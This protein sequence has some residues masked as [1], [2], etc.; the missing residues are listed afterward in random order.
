MDRLADP[1]LS[2]DE[3]VK[4]LEEPIHVM[5]HS[6]NPEER[7][8]AQALLTNIQDLP[9]AWMRV[10]KVL[11]FPPS[12]INAKFFALQI[13]EKLIKYRWKT[14]P[15]QTCESIRNYV[16][17][18]LIKLSETDDSL[19]RERVFVSKLN[20]I[21]V[22]IVKQE[23]PANWPSF[24]TEIVGASRSSVSLCEN[25]MKILRLLSEEVFEFST[26]EMTQDKIN[27][28]KNQ[29]NDDFSRVFQ[30]CQNV[31]ESSNDLQ[32]T[33][34]TLLVATLRTLEKFLSWIPLGYILETQLIEKLVSFIPSPALRNATLPC[35][36]EISSLQA[37]QRYSARFLSLYVSFAKQ[38][39]NVLPPDIDIATA[40]DNADDDTQRFVMDLALFFTGFFRTHGSL[41]DVEGP[42]Q[43]QEAL[44]IGHEYLVRISKVS[45]IEVF[46]T[47]VEWWFRLATELYDSVCLVPPV[48]SDRQDLIVL[49]G[50]NRETPTPAN[51]GLVL[52]SPDVPLPSV[53][54]PKRAFYAHILADVRHVMISRMAKPEEVLI[55]EDENGEI[56]RETTKDTDAIALYKT[57]KET[58]VGLTHLDTANTEN[59]MLTK[60][61]M[62][63]DNSEWSWNNLNTLCWAIGS[64]SGAMGEEEERKFLVTVIK[65]LLQLVEMK[66]GKDNKAV[67]ASNI[68]YVVGQ[69]PRFLRA[70]WKFLKTV[71]NKLFEFM[72]E[73]HPGVQDMACD[74]FLKIS[75]KCRR[76][77]VTVQNGESRAFIVE[78]LESVPDIILK[79]EAH[80]IHSFYEACGC[81]IASEN[82]SNSRQLI[83]KL[84]ELPN[85]SWQQLLYS[86]SFSEDVLRQREKMKS[87]TSILKTNS[88][89]A[90]PL[91]PA[92]F[93][94]LE[95]IFADMLKVYK[96]Y[97][98]L[99]QG[100]V[101]NGG[102]YATK[103]ADV[104]N[105]RAVKREVLQVI[106]T[107]ISTADEKIREHIESG[108]VEPL[109]D[110]VLADYYNSVPDAREPAVLSLYSTIV[111]YMRS[112]LPT[113]AIRVIFKSLVGCTLDMIKNNFQDFPDARINFFLLLRAINS[114]NFASLFAL[115]E[116]PGKAE[117]EFRIIINAIVW[118]F[119]HTERNVAETGLQTLLEMLRSVDF[120]PFVNYFYKI[121][122][123]SILNDIL[124]VLTDTF[125][126]PG[127]KLHAQI[128]KHL[129]TS[130]SSG[131]ITEPI[132][133][134]A[135]AEEMVLAT[136]N[137]N[138]QASNWTYLRNHLLKILKEAFPNLTDV[139]VTD[140]VTKLLSGCDEKTFKGHL[141]DFL[142]QTKEFSGGDNT[143]LFEGEKQMQMLEK[144][145][146]EKERLERTPGLVAPSN[147]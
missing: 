34:P 60:L 49:P 17:N 84:F 54:T 105:M 10:D 52:R 75:Q 116:N 147:F 20:L 51:S 31:F 67:V 130:V 106:E 89:V 14:L 92:Y 68:M 94:Q 58:L 129:I 4:L 23:W 16:V 36:V 70:H 98:G 132:W 122:F 128:L 113:P 62:Q 110:A 18:K 115:D 55:V 121:Y 48:S 123:K 104:R 45:D 137:G 69:Y 1:S 35:L 126:R 76:Q 118:A 9:N 131:R 135:T 114:H 66:R 91:G 142:V 73:T 6:Q 90:A 38:L 26:G 95:W 59:I 97:S 2:D 124:S 21:L 5:Y 127:F 99:I 82:D 120:S 41:L 136:T 111:T 78:M 3:Y 53:M 109:T 74:T 81:I 107:A 133:D 71:V 88:R 79:L 56:V 72:H 93:V 141:R 63:I 28:L 15:R 86:A 103:S 46:K 77:F 101:A 102:Q 125:H 85:N 83:M 24:I 8:R 22:Q 144:E 139:Q 61:A 143:D 39:V 138:G 43:E 40:Y 47:C 33:R 119:K 87:F 13:L 19:R 50:A 112:S 96:A 7:N 145:K 100:L 146:A 29:F 32:N 140:V 44:R 37:P 80:Q 134:Q 12:S 42:Q 64:I 27:Q 117:A 11:D 65:E 108:I 25:N 30:L 57:M